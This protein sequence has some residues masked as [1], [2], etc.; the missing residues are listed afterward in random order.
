M[1]CR[2]KNKFNYPYCWE[3]IVQHFNSQRINSH[4][5]IHLSKLHS[6][7]RFILFQLR[8]RNVSILKVNILYE[9]SAWLLSKLNWSK[10]LLQRCSRLPH[11]IWANAA[12]IIL[13]KYVVRVIY[14]FGFEI[15]QFHFTFLIARRI[16]HN[17]ILF[18]LMKELQ[19]A[20]TCDMRRMIISFWDVFLPEK[21]W[22]LWNTYRY[23]YM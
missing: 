8:Q 7:N 23:A 13:Q 5:I 1:F 3:N 14:P 10:I 2:I 17:Y 6:K 12:G 18:T 4:S 19:F 22:F 15:S 20:F 9:M 11:I 21:L 16:N